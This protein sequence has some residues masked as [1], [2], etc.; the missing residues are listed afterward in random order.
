MLAIYTNTGLNLY[1]DPPAAASTI[2]RAAIVI[3][4]MFSY[5]LQ[6]HPCRASVAAVSK[7]RPQK[8]SQEFTPAGGSQSR[9]SLLG[10]QNKVPVRPKPEDMSEL[11]F[12]VITTVII[13]L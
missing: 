6:V 13:I 7:W 8:R 4:V 5:P 12:A 9:S 1:S 11:R 10:N 2:G 3:L